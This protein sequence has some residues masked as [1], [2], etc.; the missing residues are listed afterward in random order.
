MVD[1]SLQVKPGETIAIVGPSGAGKSTLLNLIIGFLRPTSGQIKLDG[2]EMNSLDLRT[3]RQFLSVV[4]Q[5][6]ILFEGTVREN[7]L[8]GKDTVSEQ[9]LKQVVIESNADEFI[10]NLPHGLE[11]QIGENGVKLS[12][13]QRQRIAIARALIRDPRVLILDEATSSLDTVSESLIQ[14]ALDRLVQNRTTF[15]VAHR[16]S[17]IRKADRI[18]VLEKGKIIEVGNHEQLLEHQGLFAIM[19]ALQS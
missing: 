9:R 18:V 8:Y 12:G 5:E 14:E 11:T 2:K 4:S 16:L 3:Y 19:H 17:T 7:I 1:F 10:Q 15:I 6:T 13:G